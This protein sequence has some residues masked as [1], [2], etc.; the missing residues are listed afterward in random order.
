MTS[1]SNDPASQSGTDAA[2]TPAEGDVAAAPFRLDFRVRGGGL[3]A[4]VGETDGA[5]VEIHEWMTWLRVRSDLGL[6][7]L[8]LGR[9]NGDLQGQPVGLFASSLRAAELDE[10]RGLVESIQWAQLPPPT[11]G[12]V[13]A[14]TLEID[15][16]RGNL[17]INR[18]FNARSREFIAAIGSLMDPLSDKLGQ[19][20]AAPANALTAVSALSPDA[21]DPA[22]VHLRFELQNG[23]PGPIVVVDPRIPG[24]D[25]R[26]RG[27][28][29]V[30]LQTEE[31]R[32]PVWAPIDLPPLPE[33]QPEQVTLAAG[34]KLVVPVSWRA[35]QAGTYYLRADW[36][37]YVGPAAE[38]APVMPLPADL[39][40]G[41]AAHG[42][43]AVRGA[44][45]SHAVPFEVA[46]L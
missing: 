2:S 33:G 30:T 43:Y 40:E 46:K 6:A 21:H 17:L 25:R 11:G 29:M 32:P 24:A 9:H 13:T 3:M 16:A 22:L 10:L 19:M 41:Y 35:P 5:Q 12:D 14:S 1:P 28:L 37:D 44:A 45:F 20:L 26:P 7:V 18:Q 23:G 27:R 39:G 38:L 31:F 15:Y 42:A 34:A 8:I 36:I 4:T